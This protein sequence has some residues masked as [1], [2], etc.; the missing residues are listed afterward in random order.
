MIKEDPHEETENDQKS[1]ISYMD[2]VEDEELFIGK[3]LLDTRSIIKK[4]IMTI[5]YRIQ[6]YLKE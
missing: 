5:K 1:E 2:K 3:K 6:D 4:I